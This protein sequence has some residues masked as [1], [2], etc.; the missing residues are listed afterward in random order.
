MEEPLCEGRVEAC[1]R[2]VVLIKA[3]PNQRD[4]ESSE[5]L[6]TDGFPTMIVVTC[7]PFSIS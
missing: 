1:I 6:A 3:L 2:C 7:L 5:L 4:P